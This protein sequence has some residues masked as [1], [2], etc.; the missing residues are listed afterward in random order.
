MSWIWAK[1]GSFELDLF[2]PYMK[3]VIRKTSA[4]YMAESLG[5]KLI[6]TMGLFLRYISPVGS[7]WL[8]ATLLWVCDTL[9]K[10]KQE[11]P[12]DPKEERS[13]VQCS[14][15]MEAVD[16]D[17]IQWN[18]GTH[19]SRGNP[20]RL[21]WNK[22]RRGNEW[23][24][25]IQSPNNADITLKLVPNRVPCFSDSLSH[26]A[27]QQAAHQ[28]WFRTGSHTSVTRLSCHSV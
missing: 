11:I 25:N 5:P 21:I 23:P 24:F 12:R 10:L 17:I 20:R 27:I 1:T 13:I 19:L 18:C 16:D 26:P 9:T 4:K 7:R 14:E 2:A 6:Q 8:G 3:V 22:G 28:S 15:I